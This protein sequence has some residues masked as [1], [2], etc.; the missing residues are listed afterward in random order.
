MKQQSKL[1][2]YKRERSTIYTHMKTILKSECDVFWD[3]TLFSL[4]DIFSYSGMTYCLPLQTTRYIVPQHS[5]LHGQ[6]HK[7]LQS[8]I[9]SDYVYFKSCHVSESMIYLIL[10][11][12]RYI[13]RRPV[14][15]STEAER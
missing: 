3:V 5:N 4:I 14:L 2:P 8:P 10:I 7:N 13:H 1:S 12:S 11:S 9:L 15:D 6:Q